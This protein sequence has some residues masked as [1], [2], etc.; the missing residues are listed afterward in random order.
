[1]SFIQYDTRFGAG[2]CGYD[3]FISYNGCFKPLKFSKSL[4]GTIYE[5]GILTMDN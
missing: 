3:L 5:E 2:F 1:M 4:F